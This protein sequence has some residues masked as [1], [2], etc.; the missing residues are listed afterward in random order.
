MVFSEQAVVR[1]LLNGNQTG[2]SCGFESVGGLDW[3]QMLF[4]WK[5]FY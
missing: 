1:V 4:I 5:I 3:C 2:A